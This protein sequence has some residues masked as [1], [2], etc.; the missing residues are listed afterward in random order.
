[1]P[2]K[3]TALA[4][5]LA[6]LLS[7]VAGT[8]FVNLTAANFTPLPELPT[9]IY[10]REDGAIEGAEGAIQKTGNT[11]T[12]VRDVNKTIEIQKDDVTLEGNGFNLTKPPE[13]NTA[14]LMTPT[15]WFP[16]I[17]IS[18]RHNIIL[19]NIMFDRCYTSISVE[20]SSNITIIQN[21]ITDGE[22]GIDMS[23]CANCSIIGNNIADNGFTGLHLWDSSY[24]NILYNNISR[25]RGH[26]AWI[27]IDYSNISRN[28]FSHNTGAN[29]GIGLYCYGTNSHNYIFENNFINNDEGL[30]YQHGS[31]NTLYHNYWSNYRKEIGGNIVDESPLRSPISISFDPSLFSWLNP[32]PTPFEE[33]LSTPESEQTAPFPASL[34]AI[35]SGASLA[36]VGVSLPLYFKKRKR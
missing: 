8:Q 5:I 10:I 2:M 33:T 1:M 18:N 22:L 23:S 12:F 11:Y 35:A 14:G 19:R 28:D 9:P 27:T 17:R 6:L 13:V 30:A 36:F 3:R 31:N 29:V 21:S 24:L 32:T 26:G 15:G 34:V 4:L 7:A 25:N 20:Q 16:S